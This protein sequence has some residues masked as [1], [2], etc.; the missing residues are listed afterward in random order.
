M[1]FP[2]LLFLLCFVFLF[3][4]ESHAS[5]N[6][7]YYCTPI[8]K[9]TAQCQIAAWGDEGCFAATS[10]RF[11]FK[12]MEDKVIFDSSFIFQELELAVQANIDDG[13]AAQSSL[14]AGR[15]NDA[16]VWFNGKKLIFAYHNEYYGQLLIADCS[17]F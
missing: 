11:T 12:K 10:E 15:R 13:F 1:R 9:G 14:R 16:S 4:R 7:V 17:K 8:N 2:F 6:G 3:E 5:N